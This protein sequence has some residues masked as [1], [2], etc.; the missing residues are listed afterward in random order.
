MRRTDVGGSGAQ[1]APCSHLLMTI[2]RTAARAPAEPIAE[3]KHS[4]CNAGKNISVAAV[5]AMFYDKQNNIVA[6]VVP[7]YQAFS[8]GGD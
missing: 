7:K 3:Q 4:Q 5:E 1:R 6:S 8:G 2:D